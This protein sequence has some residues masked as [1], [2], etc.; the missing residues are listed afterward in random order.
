ME[1]KK[2]KNEKKQTS[3]GP[4]NKSGPNQLIWMYKSTLIILRSLCSLAVK[5]PAL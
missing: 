5:L 3:D 2:K 1:L 4:K